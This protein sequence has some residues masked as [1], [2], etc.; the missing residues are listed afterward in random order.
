MEYTEI[1]LVRRCSSAIL[2]VPAPPEPDKS[3]ARGTARPAS[4]LRITPKRCACVRSTPGSSAILMFGPHK[5]ATGRC[6]AIP[7]RDASG[8]VTLLGEWA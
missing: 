3:F 7:C 2:A 5:G 8:R 1:V 6:D 4:I